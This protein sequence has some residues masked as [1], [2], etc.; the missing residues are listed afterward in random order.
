MP[1]IWNFLW[2]CFG[3]DW[4]LQSSGFSFFGH[5][6]YMLC[7]QIFLHD[8]LGHQ[9]SLVEEFPLKLGFLWAKVLCTGHAANSDKS[10]QNGSVFFPLRSFD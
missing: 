3:R 2:L 4:S 10:I 8:L 5:G 1:H 7:L 6:P 9:V